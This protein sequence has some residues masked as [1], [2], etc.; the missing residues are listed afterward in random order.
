MSK[1]KSNNPFKANVNEQDWICAGFVASLLC[2]SGSCYHPEL[3]TK[4][5]KSEKKKTQTFKSSL[6]KV[7]K[8]DFF[9]KKTETLLVWDKSKLKPSK[10][11]A[12]TVFEGWGT[13]WDH[14]M[15][16]NGYNKGVFAERQCQSWAGTGPELEGLTKAGCETCLVKYIACSV[17]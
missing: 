9:F 11:V 1:R 12:W 4:H 5:I 8:V 17:Y 3:I 16:C 14:D 6:R 7:L 2:S 10:L 15:V 13:A